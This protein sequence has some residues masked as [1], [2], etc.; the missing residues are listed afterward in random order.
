MFG[1]GHLYQGIARLIMHV[2]MMLVRRV[3][4]DPNQGLVITGILSSPRT[5][6][7]PYA[8]NKQHNIPNV[9]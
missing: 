3:Y 6:D 2:F 4:H 8:P 7:N 1:L 9:G 5:G